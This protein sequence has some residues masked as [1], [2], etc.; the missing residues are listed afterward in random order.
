MSLAAYS[1]LMVTSSKDLNMSLLD[2]LQA[3]GFIVFTADGAESA[4]AS[5]KRYKPSLVIVDL[6]EPEGLAEDVIREVAAQDLDLPVIVLSDANPDDIQYIERL[7]QLG[8]VDYMIKPI[9]ELTQ[10]KLAVMNA[11]DKG[12]LLTENLLY[13]QQLESANIE[14]SQTV[15]KLKDDQEAGRFVQQKLFP[16]S[17]CFYYGCELGYQVVP[18]SYLSGDFV[19][20]FRLDEHRFAFYLADVSGHGSSSAFITLLLKVSTAEHLRNFKKHRSDIVSRPAKILHWFNQE[21][22]QL[23]LGKHLTMFYGVID[24]K[25]NTLTYSIAAHF[26]LP[27]LVNDGKVNMIESSTLPVGVFA[28][29]VYEEVTI[30]LSKQFSLI[31]FSDGI[32]EMLK[33]QSLAE[34]EQYLLGLVESGHDDFASLAK[35][36]DLANIRSAPDDISLMVVARA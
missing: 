7:L 26:P 1:V 5:I 10:L 2:K 36:L 6:Q 19:D 16:P 13:R 24:S 9:P 4:Y 14:L 12:R 23:D 32:M 25:E 31:M 21:L 27:I 11:I 34:K 20:Y 30:P 15:K 18:S 3:A 33:Q 17:P 22:I 28:D 29:A 35:K 8:A